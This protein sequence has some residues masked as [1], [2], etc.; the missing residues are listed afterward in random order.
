MWPITP[1]RNPA[2]APRGGARCR[3]SPNATSLGCADGLVPS[4]GRRFGKAAGSRG[5]QARVLRVGASHGLFKGC[6][7]TFPMPVTGGGDKPLRAA[8]RRSPGLYWR[9]SG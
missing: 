2:T 1:S 8:C 7:G 6:R 4:D 9:H 3:S 5:E